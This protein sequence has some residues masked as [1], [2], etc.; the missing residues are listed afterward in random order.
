MRW[1]A[2]D[3]KLLGEIWR[4]GFPIGASFFLEVAVFSVISLLIAT[5]GNT[6]MA[7]HQIAFNVWDIVYIL[8]ISIGSAMATRVGHAIGARDA[9]GVKRAIACGGSANLLVGGVGMALLLSIPGLIISAYTQDSDIHVMASALIA[10]AALFIL[11]DATQV[12]VTF[13]LRAFK[14]TQYP[15]YVLCGCYWFITL[16]VGY[17]L[18]I[19]I[20]DDPQTGTMGFWKAM[21]GGI[22]LTTIILVFRLRARLRMPLPESSGVQL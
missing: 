6:A 15:F 10:L 13:S 1:V 20:A 21:I 5:L 19:V 12:T 2:P 11:I 14:D 18:G 3:P 9:A 17:W 8:L 16:P 4:I 22:A 7:S